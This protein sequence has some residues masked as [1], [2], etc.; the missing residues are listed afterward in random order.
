MRTSPILAG[1]LLPLAAALIRSAQAHTGAGVD[2][3]GPVAYQSQQS[4]S[5]GIPLSGIIFTLALVL[6]GTHLFSKLRYRY[7]D[8]HGNLLIGT[9][10]IIVLGLGVVAYAAPSHEVSVTPPV[11]FTFYFG[12]DTGYYSGLLTQAIASNQ[13]IQPDFFLDLGDIS[14]NGTT[15]GHP[16]TGNEV[17]WCNFIKDN[18][19]NRLG[20]PNFP[21]MFVTGNH[22]DGSPDPAN[23]YRD[24][25]IDAFIGNNCLPLSAFNSQSSAG[26]GFINFIG[27]DLCPESNSCYGKEGYFDYP[28]A[29]P[30]ARVITI[31]VADTV[32][33]STDPSSNVNFNYCPLSVCNNPG[34]DTHWNWLTGVISAAKA[35]GLWLLVAFHKPCLSPDLNTGCEGNGDYN[36]HNP[37]YQLE[38][39]LTS[40]GVDILLNGHSHIYARSKQLTCLGSTEPASDSTVGITYDPSCVANNGS[41]GFYKRGAGTVEVIQGVFSQR[42]DQL[43][44]SRPDINYFAE[45]MSAR[46]TIDTSKPG[47]L[48]DCC[49]VN[50]APVD[51]A[52]GNGVGMMTINATHASYKWL[53]SIFS[54]NSGSSTRFS[55]SFVIGPQ[56][57]SVNPPTVTVDTP[58]PSIASTGQTVT[59]NFSIDSATTV[60]SITVDWGDGTI[61]NPGPSSTSDTHVYTT[62]EYSQSHT[63]TVNVMA[64]NSAGQAY[65]TTTETIQD[66]PPSLAITSLLP[67]PAISGQQ[68]TLDFTAVDPDGI[69]ATTWVDWG[70]GSR[71]DLIFNMTSGSMCPRLISGHGTNSCAIAPGDL[72]FAQSQDPSKIINGSILIFRPFLQTPDF[73]VVHRVVK[74]LSPAESTNNEYTFSTKGDANAVADPWTIPASRVVAVYQYTMTPLSRSSERYDVHTFPLLGSAQS[75]SYT[76]RLNATDDSGSHSSLTSTVIVNP[77]PS[78]TV[79]APTILGLTPTVFYAIIGSII[80]AVV[81]ATVLA[82]RG[83]KRPVQADIGSA[84]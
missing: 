38:T 30:I 20:N 21:Y 79:P 60:S 37:N 73:L 61:T 35:S 28:A 36:G 46:G 39:Y 3:V 40:Q 54:H 32:G 19:H 34:M 65:A 81:A 41:S 57:S 56:P 15:N 42:N 80:I 47:T 24:G 29:N 45:A 68:V 25:Y 70:D 49:W 22:E 2:I 50:D 23:L 82:L 63:Y 51:M 83:R 78:E 58:T 66:M 76:L 17:D 62:T 27:S 14:Y 52:S 77:E 13:L 44:F 8:Y 4:P 75:K 11:S 55:D 43:N 48:N 69:V 74:I 16:P 59:V 67:R 10:L 18:V 9:S 7:P 12:G 26:S 5:P 33:N 71:P 72:I 64:T 6:L 31:T 53:P 84:S 1:L